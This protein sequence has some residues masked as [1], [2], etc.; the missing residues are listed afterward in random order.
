MP[1]ILVFMFA[2]DFLYWSDDSLHAVERVNRHTGL[3]RITIILYPNETT[4][5][6]IKSVDAW[7]VAGE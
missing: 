2:G 1:P 7:S 3:D 4:P 6:G 5:I